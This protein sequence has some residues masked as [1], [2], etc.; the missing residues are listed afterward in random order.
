MNECAAD[1]FNDFL[2]FNLLN[3]LNITKSRL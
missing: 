3:K 2:R 1:E